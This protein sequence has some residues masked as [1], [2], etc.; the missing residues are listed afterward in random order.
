[1]CSNF[2]FDLPPFLLGFPSDMDIVVVDED[3]NTVAKYRASGAAPSAGEAIAAAG[4]G[5]GYLTDK[6]GYAVAL[7]TSLNAAEGPYVWRPTAGSFL[8][9]ALMQ[10]GF[11]TRPNPW[12]YWL[13][14]ALSHGA[15]S[16][17]ETLAWW[18]EL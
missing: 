4:R 17:V 11:L 3:G 5:L 12:K 2:R 7:A 18:W 1:M 10:P 9:R 6:D 14:V 13:D 15:L 16:Q 8:L